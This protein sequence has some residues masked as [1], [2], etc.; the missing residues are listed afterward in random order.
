MGTSV[1]ISRGRDRRVKAGKMKWKGY[2]KS[3]GAIEGAHRKGKELRSRVR[4]LEEEVEKQR[5]VIIEGAEE[6]REAIRQ[7]CFSLE[8][9]RN[10]YHRLRQAFVRHK[11]FPVMAA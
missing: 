8:H 10:G 7:L 5:E 1:P 3:N 4:E 6:K 9:Y 2:F 11:R